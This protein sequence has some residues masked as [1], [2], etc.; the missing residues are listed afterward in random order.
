M[1]DLKEYLDLKKQH[2][3]LDNL[4]RHVEAKVPQDETSI[5]IE[6][7]ELLGWFLVKIKDL[8]DKANE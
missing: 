2:L 7:S 5:M 4:V 3:K 6:F 8:E 1:S